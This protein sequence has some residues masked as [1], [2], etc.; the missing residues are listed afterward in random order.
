MKKMIVRADDVGYTEVCNIGTF[1][2]IEE[3]VVTSADIM[4]DAPGTVDALRR[5]KEMPW[6]STGW[7]AHFWCSPVLEPDQVPSLLIKGTNRFRHDLKDAEDISKK[8]LLDECRAQ[9]ERCIEIMGK[10]PDTSDYR[11]ESVYG[12][13]CRQICSEYGIAYGIARKNTRRD[14]LQEPDEKW[15][16]R[17]ILIADPQNAYDA[18][19]TDNVMKTSEYDPASYYIDDPDHLMELPEDVIIEQSWHPGYVDYFVYELGDYGPRA[20]YFTVGRTKDVEALCSERLKSW[21]KE[22]KIELINFRDALY[23]TSEYQNHLRN[24]KSDLYMKK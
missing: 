2:A 21:V 10:V 7:H 9:M 5:L 19:Q 15:K 3:G 8:E 24:I 4:L 12:D 23:G 11:P 20:K 18:L 16:S 13:V 1:K 22:K 6:I 14:G 17:N